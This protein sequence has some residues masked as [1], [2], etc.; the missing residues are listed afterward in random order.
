MDQG[1]K[2]TIRVTPNVVVEMEKVLLFRWDSEYRRAL[3]TYQGSP[4]HA[5]GGVSGYEYARMPIAELV[6][7]FSAAGVLMVPAER[8]NQRGGCHI[9]LALASLGREFRDNS[10]STA[11]IELAGLPQQRFYVYD[12]KGASL[13]AADFSDLKKLHFSPAVR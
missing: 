6:Q 4:S 5:V 13:S 7:A 8:A 2:K 1:E 3:L 9:N 11:L 12:P 10:R